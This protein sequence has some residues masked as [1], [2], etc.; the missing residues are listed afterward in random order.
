[1]VK[2]I[3]RDNEIYLANSMNSLRIEGQ[4]TIAL[5]LCQQFGWEVP[6]YIIIPGGN[7]GNVSALGKGFFELQ[8]L[9]IINKIPVIIVAQVE[10]ANPL[11]RAYQNGFRNYQPVTARKTQ[12]SAIQIGDPVSVAKAV[13]V[14]Q[15]ADGIVEQVS[16]KELADAAAL[17]DTTGMFNCP[18]TGTA[19]AALLKQLEKGTV[20]KKSKVVVISTAHGLKFTEFKVNYH[21][22]K[23]DFTPAYSNEPIP[24]PADFSK[25]KDLLREKVFK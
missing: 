18:H 24:V 8:E 17:G 12:A 15:K 20:D 25:I 3:T 1:L 13:R 2:E 6:D 11:Y 19:L 7:L 5:E 4:K 10:N 22:K 14:L 23:V 16:E 21:E 9:E